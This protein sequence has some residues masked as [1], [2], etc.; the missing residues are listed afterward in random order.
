MNK[1]DQSIQLLLD[2]NIGPINILKGL[3][4]MDRRDEILVNRLEQLKANKC[5]IHIR[6]LCCTDDE[7]QKVLNKQYTASEDI[8]YIASINATKSHIESEIIQMIG[9]DFEEAA[10]IYHTILHPGVCMEHV[11]SNIEYLKQLGADNDAIKSNFQVTLMPFD[12][13]CRR[14]GLLCGINSISI[15]DLLPLVSVNDAILS[16]FIENVRDNHR[17]FAYF[18]KKLNVPIMDIFKSFATCP[19]TLRQQPKHLEAKLNILLAHDN[20]DKG[21]ILSGVDVFLI[22]SNTIRTQLEELSK[23]GTTKIQ[24]YMLTEQKPKIL[25]ILERREEE[26]QALSEFSGSTLKY[27]SSRFRWTDGQAQAAAQAKP[28]LLKLTFDKVRIVL[29]CHVHFFTFVF[30]IQ[31]LILIS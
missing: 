20:F 5:A 17:A 14:L 10:Q 27:L 12:V 9:C 22:T 15:V 11:K 13:L 26:K 21:S 24:A 2:Y 29:L 7:F 1:L 3:Y 28:F 4:A 25:A 18:S 30:Y 19:D 8:N 16:N 31:L 23:I 6:H